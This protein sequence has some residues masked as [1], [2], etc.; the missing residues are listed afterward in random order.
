MVYLNILTTKTCI[1]LF[2]GLCDVL[3][4][5]VNVVI[6]PYYFCDLTSA[7]I[8]V[9]LNPSSMRICV[10]L[11]SDSWV[12]GETLGMGVL[13]CFGNFSHLL[14]YRAQNRFHEEDNDTGECVRK[15][16]YIV[17]LLFALSAV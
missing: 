11:M 4:R 7:Q 9:P 1:R 16:L 15:E 8:H 3:I 17:P 6:G 13:I 10:E 5:Y 14:P 2:L 12:A